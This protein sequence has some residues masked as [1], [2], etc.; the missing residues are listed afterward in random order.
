[1]KKKEEIR[2][3]ENIEEK[4][5]KFEKMKEI[6]H[7][8]AGTVKKQSSYSNK[9]MPLQTQ[10]YW[11]IEFLRAA[12]KH[13]HQRAKLILKRYPYLSKCLFKHGGYNLIGISEHVGLLHSN[14]TF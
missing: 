14:R 8:A 3:D 2:K 13:D 11:A 4:V 5:R 6:I 12:Y 1:M 7:K 9:D 10:I